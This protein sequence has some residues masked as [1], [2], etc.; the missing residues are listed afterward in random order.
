MI[1]DSYEDVLRSFDLCTSQAGGTSLQ[2]P[3]VLY[4]CMEH[5][6]H[7]SFPLGSRK[8]P[9]LSLLQAPTLKDKRC[10]VGR[11]KVFLS[12]CITTPVENR[13]ARE[14]IGMQDRSSLLIKASIIILSF[15]VCLFD[16]YTYP[17]K[18]SNNYWVES[19]VD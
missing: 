17:K 1:A 14:R 13:I 19:D 4:S 6:E 3:V 16:C 18:I 12:P 15:L 7:S 2:I 5:P 9:G 11:W 10:S 8:Q